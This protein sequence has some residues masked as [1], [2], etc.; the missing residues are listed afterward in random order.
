M[1]FF[2]RSKPTTATLNSPSALTVRFIKDDKNYTAE[3]AV[4]REENNRSYHLH[5]DVFDSKKTKIFT[6]DRYGLD[7]SQVNSALLYVFHQAFSE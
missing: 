2:Q 1:K 3:F 7:Y 5:A 4:T 6:K